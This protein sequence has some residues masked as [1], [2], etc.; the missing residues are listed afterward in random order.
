MDFIM[1][2]YAR[3]WRVSVPFTPVLLILFSAGSPLLSCLVFVC[4]SVVVTL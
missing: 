1:S 3:A 2:V 4:L